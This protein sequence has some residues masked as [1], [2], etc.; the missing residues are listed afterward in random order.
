MTPTE[1][2]YAKNV[3]KLFIAKDR[4]YNM[5]KQKFE[6]THTLCFVYGMYRTGYNGKNGA[7]GYKI[8]TLFPKLEQDW[9][10]DYTIRCKEFNEGGRRGYCSG[11]GHWHRMDYL[12]ATPE[13]TELIGKVI[14]VPENE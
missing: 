12:P 1:K 13:N 7:Y 14:D 5:D 3:G 10:M 2:Q 8:Q 6:H 11:R 9:R 4:R